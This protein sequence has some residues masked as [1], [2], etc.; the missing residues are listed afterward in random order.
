MRSMRWS[1]LT[2]LTLVV[3]ALAFVVGAAT[4]FRGAR[5]RRKRDSFGALLEHDESPDGTGYV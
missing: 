1:R 5:H 3:L 2:W 4:F